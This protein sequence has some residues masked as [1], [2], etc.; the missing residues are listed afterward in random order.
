M[1]F[2]LILATL[3]C[4]FLVLRFLY[5]R[6]LQSLQYRQNPKNN[7]AGPID[8]EAMIQCRQCGIYL[9]ASEAVSGPSSQV[10][11]SD[12]HRQRYSAAR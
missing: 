6:Y 12:D 8:A 7:V 2:L 10:F 5:S 9:P 1:R 11:C 3:V 4:A